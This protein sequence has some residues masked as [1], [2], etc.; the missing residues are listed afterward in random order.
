M[1]VHDHQTTIQVRKLLGLS[2]RLCLPIVL[3]KEK[4]VL[5]ERRQIADTNNNASNNNNNTHT[6][7]RTHARTHAH[8]HTHTHTNKKYLTL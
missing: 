4:N 5:I 6:H 1:F 8:T 7:A 2:L 3:M